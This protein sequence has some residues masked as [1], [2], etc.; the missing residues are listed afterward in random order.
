MGEGGTGDFTRRE[1]AARWTTAAIPGGLRA[2]VADGLWLKVYLAWAARDLPRTEG[3]IRLVTLVDDRPLSFWIN[4]A[5]IVAYDIPEWRLSSS[6]SGDMPAEVRRRIVEEQACAGL[7]LLDAARKCHGETA[8]LWV[9]MGNIQLYRRRDLVLAAE[10]YRHAAESPDAPYFAARVYAELL[11]RIGREQEA[12]AWLCRIH[13]QLPVDDES[14][15]S[16][17]VLWRIRELERRLDV[18]GRERY[19]APQNSP[20]KQN[21]R[22]DID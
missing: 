5:R 21:V 12:Y 9:E 3:L 14:A 2:L 22:R 11:R 6:D 15:M 19:A 10:C 20:R 1:I 8:A 4:G 13:P 7:R 17:L 18:P 16:G